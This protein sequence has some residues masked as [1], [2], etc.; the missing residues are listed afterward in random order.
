MTTR[1]GS[2]LAGHHYLAEIISHARR[3]ERAR[4]LMDI[5]HTEK[6]SRKIKASLFKCLEL[7]LAM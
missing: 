4:L 3:G 2:R 6:F 7:I 5:K 1:P